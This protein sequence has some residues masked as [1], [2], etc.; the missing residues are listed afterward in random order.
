M[1]VIDLGQGTAFICE[2][3]IVAGDR[4]LTTD[5]KETRDFAASLR[6]VGLESAAAQV[7][8]NICRRPST[9]GELAIMAA[10]RGS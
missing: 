1:C 10:G 5:S 9:H 3:C 7:E 6:E 4:S 2:Q 8:A